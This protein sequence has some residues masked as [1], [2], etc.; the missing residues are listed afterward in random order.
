MDDGSQKVF[1]GYRIRHDDSRGP[2]KGGLRFHP[3]VNLEEVKALAFW[4]TCKCALMGIPFGG[5]K[6]GVA[7]NPHELS[8]MELERLSRAF[9][10]QVSDFIGP[11]RDIPAPDVY[12]N[13]TIMGW[14]ADE[15]GLEKSADVGAALWTAEQVLHLATEA[16]GD[17]DA[18][19]HLVVLGDVGAVQVRGHVHRGLNVDDLE[20][21]ELDCEVD[22]HQMDR[23]RLGVSSHIETSWFL[24]VDRPTDQHR[25]VIHLVGI[26]V[27][28]AIVNQGIGRDGGKF[29]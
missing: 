9:I 2:T 12:T 28:V 3:D 7:V 16:S 21:R 20:G 15:N 27:V 25:V 19:Q 8:R 18:N 5:A 23:Q 24:I 11:N 13:P 14:M 22:S 1:Q 29:G 6:G 10:R 4:M 17:R 26:H